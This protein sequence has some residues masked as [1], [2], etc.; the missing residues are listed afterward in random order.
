VKSKPTL[1]NNSDTNIKPQKPST[2]LLTLYHCF[3][4]C[5]IVFHPGVLVIRLVD[6]PAIK[7]HPTAVLIPLP[8]GIIQPQ[9]QDLALCCHKNIVVR[10]VNPFLS[11]TSILGITT[12]ILPSSIT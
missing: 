5:I 12:I 3:E 6:P 9:F 7:F 11:K 4:P 10:P 8:S 2:L 1:Y